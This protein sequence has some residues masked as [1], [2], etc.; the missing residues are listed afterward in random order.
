MLE[1]HN[2]ADHVSG[3]GRLARATGATIHINRLADAEYPHEAFDDGWVA[4]SSARSRSRRC[5]PP[6]TGPSTPRSCCATA[7]R[8]AE[9]V[10]GADRRLAVRRRR[11]PARPRGR[12]R[13][14][15]GGALPL[16]ARAA[17]HAA[18]RGRGLARAPRRLA[19]RQL[20][21][22]PP[23]LVD[24]RLRARAQ[25]ALSR[26]RRPR[27]SSPT[28]S[29]RSA[30]GRRTSSTSSPSTAGRWSRSWARP[31]PL[32]PRAVEVAIAD[33]ALLVDA[34]TNEQFDEAHIPGA[35]SA[36]AYD[37]GFGDQGRPDRRRPTSS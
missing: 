8:G 20:R 3:H 15:R 32:T 16:A 26:S 21:D 4:A 12:A 23:D 17:V 22:R 34:R 36:S 30:T 11:R 9:P 25:P 7:G 28:R 14:G 2:H 6:A 13:G 19:V 31:T 37:T 10:R 29:P 1:T 18:R 27:S 35:I 33:G 24:D 5:T